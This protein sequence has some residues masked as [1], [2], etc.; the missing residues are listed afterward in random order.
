MKLNRCHIVTK[1]LFLCIVGFIEFVG[2]PIALAHFSTRILP[3]D[4]VIPCLISWIERTL[5]CFTVYEIIILITRK[6]IVD[7]KK[8]MLL[9]LKNAYEL[10]ELCIVSNNIDIRGKA[11]KLIDAQMDSGLLNNLR[12]RDDY[13]HLKTFIEHRRLDELKCKKIFI[14]HSLEACSLF[15]ELTLFLRFFK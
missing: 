3:F 9:A 12:V 6:L 11:Y 10:G 1:N 4:D 7:A 8:D 14:N 15:W 2:I 5:L 13:Q